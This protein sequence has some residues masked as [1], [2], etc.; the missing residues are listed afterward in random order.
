MIESR[1]VNADLIVIKKPL[2]SVTALKFV[3]STL[4]TRARYLPSTQ[5]LETLGVDLS[6]EQ[7]M[8][9]SMQRASGRARAEL[10]QLTANRRV[11]KAAF[12]T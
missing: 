4:V 2:R 11:S 6:D 3:G 5:E 12:R 1:K 7:C 10:E 8:G 9:K